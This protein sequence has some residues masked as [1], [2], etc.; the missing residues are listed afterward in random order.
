MV[1]LRECGEDQRCTREEVS[2]PC[3]ICSTV[4]KDPRESCRYSFA[5]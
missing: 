3:L 1:T 5:L 4:A 2:R